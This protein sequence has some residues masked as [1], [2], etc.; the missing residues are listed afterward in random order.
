MFTLASIVLMIAVFGKM[1][2]LAIR[3]AWGLSKVL[4]GIVFLPLTL[5]FMALGGLIHLAFI[6]LVIVGIVSLFNTAAA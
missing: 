5:I 3:A 2:G 4:L 6:A 1:A